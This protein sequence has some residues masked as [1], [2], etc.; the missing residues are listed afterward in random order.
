[1][2]IPTKYPT[3]N[4]LKKVHDVHYVYNEQFNRSMTSVEFDVKSVGFFWI[5]E[6]PPAPQ[7]NSELKK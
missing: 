7:G 3:K 4:P 5:L 2:K 6:A 1:M